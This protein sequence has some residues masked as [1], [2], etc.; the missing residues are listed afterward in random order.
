MTPT[1]HSDTVG[2]GP[3]PKHG[4]KLGGSLAVSVQTSW[5]ASQS[6]QSTSVSASKSAQHAV[7]APSYYE[8]KF[9]APVVT[10]EELLACLGVLQEAAILPPS[11]V[12][13]LERYLAVA[14]REN[15]R[16]MER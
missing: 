9:A 8:Q 13:T 6:A 7:F 2:I 14:V 4:K 15:S 1:P 11:S 16:P 10:Q 3:P 5:K 12:R